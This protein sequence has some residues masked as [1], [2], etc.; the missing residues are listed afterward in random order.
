MFDKL[1]AE[2][3][4][5]EDLMRLLGT[6]EVQSDAAEFRR[7]AKALADLEPLVQKYREYK[8][9][10]HDVAGAEELA[11]SGDA[12]MRELARDE[13]KALTARREALLAELKVLLVPR[14]P[15]D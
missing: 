2:E 12:E 4:R 7:S 13:L 14:D 8:S 11:A 3:Q 15:N 10:D 9:V 5:Y 1:A 6:A